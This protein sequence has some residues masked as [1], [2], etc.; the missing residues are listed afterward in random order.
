M[1]VS[2]GSVILLVHLRLGS[3]CCGWLVGRLACDVCGVV[4]VVPLVCFVMFVVC[5]FWVGFDGGLYC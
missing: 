2:C 3:L 1:F 5:L 4:V